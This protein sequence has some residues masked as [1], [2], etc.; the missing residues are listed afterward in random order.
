MHHKKVDYLDRNPISLKEQQ[1]QFPFQDNKRTLKS[2]KMLKNNN[3]LFLHNHHNKQTIKHQHLDHY[4]S[5]LQDNRLI[6]NRLLLLKP[7][8]EINKSHLHLKGLKKK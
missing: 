1:Q 7:I 3:F 5:N 2:K 4:S 8:L 6:K